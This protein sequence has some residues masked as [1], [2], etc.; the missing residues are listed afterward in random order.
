MQEIVETQGFLD[1]AR[2]KANY[3]TRKR[4]IPFITLINF[5]LAIVHESLRVAVRRFTEKTGTGKPVT[6]QALSKARNKINWEAFEY[7]FDENVKF[8]YDGDYETWNGYRVWA[9]DGSKMA[10][11]NHPKLAKLFGA[12]KGSPTARASILYDV[13]NKV[14]C[15]AAIEPLTVDERTLAQRHIAALCD[16]LNPQKEM[17]IV[18]RGYASLGL[19]DNL[20]LQGVFFVMRLR[21]KWNVDIDNLAT[22][23]HNFHLGEHN[24]RVVKFRLDTGEI[25]TLL[26]NLAGNFDFKGLYWMRWGVETEY[27]VL[28][29]ALEITNFSVTNSLW[30]IGKLKKK[31]QRNA[32]DA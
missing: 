26:T 15:H 9:I 28:K 14:I 19:I 31:P 4:C 16:K 17:V 22:G 24:L 18:D 25:E 5:L 12:D 21:K 8:I 6:E 20:T 7:L 27:D 23:D 3:F 30:Y 2:K 1:R 11:P 10:L 29:N 32:R 13:I